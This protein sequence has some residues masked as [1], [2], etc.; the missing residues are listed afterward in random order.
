[1]VKS[2]IAW[3]RAKALEPDNAALK[4][5]KKGITNEIG[6]N[7]ATTVK[8]IFGKILFGRNRSR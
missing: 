6:D 7:T 2:R 5:E 3:G 1:M 4:D 8:E